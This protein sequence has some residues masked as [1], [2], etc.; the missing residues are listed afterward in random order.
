MTTEYFNFAFYI[1]MQKVCE[2]LGVNQRLQHI[3]LTFYNMYYVSLVI[4]MV[5]DEFFYK[6]DF[7]IFCDHR[8]Y[9][10]NGAICLL[11][12]LKRFIVYQF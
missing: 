9:L 4:I 7:R 8:N 2:N 6:L 5:I 11:V 12:I 10:D 1:T 3:N